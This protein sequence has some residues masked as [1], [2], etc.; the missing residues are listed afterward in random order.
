ML[1]WSVRDVRRGA[2][3]ASEAMLGGHASD[4]LVL[5]EQSMLPWRVAG[6]YHGDRRVIS[7]VRVDSR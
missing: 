7:C 4:V 2:A 6:C 5:F 1:A 3:G